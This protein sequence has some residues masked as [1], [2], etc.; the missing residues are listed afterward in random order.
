MTGLGREPVQRLFLG[1]IVELLL[2][3][4]AEFDPDTRVRSDRIGTELTRSTPSSAA[5]A[6]DLR[7]LRGR[8]LGRRG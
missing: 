5:Y 2:G 7:V 8:D 6:G 4:V 3:R 1:E